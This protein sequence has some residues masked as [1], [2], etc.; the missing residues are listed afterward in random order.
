MS[1]ARRS[2][3]EKRRLSA[4]FAALLAAAACSNGEASRAPGHG[5]EA[6]V[7]ELVELR[8]ELLVD[9][10]ELLGQLEAELSVRLRP[11]TTGIVA[12]IDFVEGQAVRKGDVLVRLQD[13]QPRAWLAEAE[14]ERELKRSVY[15]RTLRL[16]KQD[17]SSAAQL[18]RAAAEL[19]RETA[20]VEASR[21]ALEKTRIRAPFDGMVGARLVAPGARVEPDVVLTQIDAIERL[22][23]VFTLPESALGV[24][25]PGLRFEARV[26]P[27]PGETFPGEIFFVAPTVD[28]ATRRVL[29]KGW[30]AN[31]DLRLRPGLFANL[32]G[33]IGRRENALL[34]PES[35]LALDRDGS[36][37]WRLKADDTAERV[38]VET[39][40][41][42][43]G[44]VEI[45]RGLA[46]GDR[47]VA[48]GTNKVHEG[49]VLRA[50]APADA[51][52]PD[53]HTAGA[54]PAAGGGS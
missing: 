5:P 34:V 26:A 49:S 47:V 41:R 20:R 7:V 51:S 48:A 9:Q 18:D 1:P 33:E 19:A 52:A 15:E 42:A 10:V 22:Q 38:R 4:A 30:I 3:T 2:A 13:D 21:A 46:A 53:P 35:A 12:S 16:V 32:R 37:V 54:R 8:P 6:V 40:L 36:F 17:I 43:G 31:P 39:G 25:R 44:R 27:F 29:V 24:A 50:A 14:A 28:P 45:T 11:D 23:A